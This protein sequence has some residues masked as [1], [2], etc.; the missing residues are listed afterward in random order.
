M[1]GTAVLGDVP[2]RVASKR[3]LKPRAQ[4]DDFP[5][6]MAFQI[7]EPLDGT[8]RTE[9]M[10]RHGPLCQRTLHLAQSDKRSTGHTAAPVQFLDMPSVA[11]S[12]YRATA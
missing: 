4:C 6:G 5:G 10:V 8:G 3:T 7:T 11:T 9:A 1:R 12:Q 2:R